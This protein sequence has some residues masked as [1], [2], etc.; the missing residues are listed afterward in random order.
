MKI[1]IPSILAEAGTAPFDTMS[2]VQLNPAQLSTDPM[3]T[4]QPCCLRSPIQRRVR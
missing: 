3:S 4:D 2:P 1:F